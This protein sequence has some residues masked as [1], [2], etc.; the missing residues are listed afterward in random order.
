MTVVLISSLAALVG[1][2]SDDPQSSADDAW[3]AC[4]GAVADQVKDGVTAKFGDRADATIEE[5]D[6]GWTVS[7]DLTGATDDAAGPKLVFTCGLDGEAEVVTAVVGS[8]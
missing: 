6:E 5:S 8:G 7:G 3:A 4:R 1:C 2:S